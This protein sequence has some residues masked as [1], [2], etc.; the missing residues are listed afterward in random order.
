MKMGQ[1]FVESKKLLVCPTACRKWSPVNGTLRIVYLRRLM[2]LQNDIET[3]LSIVA[4]PFALQQV[5][6]GTLQSKLKLTIMQCFILFSSHGF[7]GGMQEGATY[8]VLSEALALLVLLLLKL[9]I[10]QSRNVSL[11]P[12]LKLPTRTVQ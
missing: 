9:E 3:F 6:Q 10:V 5:L 8:L 4:F 1:T 7:S 11:L 12:L 2:Q